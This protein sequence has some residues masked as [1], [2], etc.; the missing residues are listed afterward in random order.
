[1]SDYQ[2]GNNV[3]KLLKKSFAVFTLLFLSAQAFATP[4]TDGSS[5]VFVY[6]VADDGRL[7]VDFGPFGYSYSSIIG[8]IDNLESTMARIE[9]ETGRSLDGTQ[10]DHWWWR[11]S[12]HSDRM[13]HVPEPGTLLLFGMGLLGLTSAARRRKASQ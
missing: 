3:K 7:W 5:D 1:M 13:L 8:G 11:K 2:R 6:W 12:G 10:G 4:I 9:G